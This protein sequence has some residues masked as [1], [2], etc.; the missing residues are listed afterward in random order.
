M[1]VSVNSPGWNVRTTGAARGAAKSTAAALPS[2][3]MDFLTEASRVSDEV[4][5]EPVSS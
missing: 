4:V 3:R 1:S 2:L 5:L